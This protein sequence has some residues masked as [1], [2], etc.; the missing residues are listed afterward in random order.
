MKKF[1]LSLACVLGLGTAAQAQEAVD[2]IAAVLASTSGTTVTVSSD[3]VAVGQ[4]GNNLWIKDSSG[5]ILVYGSTDQTYENG[6]VIPAGYGGKFSPYKNLPE[7]ASP[8]GF[9]KG[10]NAGAVAPTACTAAN[11]IEQPLCSY[12]EIRGEVVATGTTGRNFTLTDASG[13]VA[14]YTTSASVKVNTG[15]DVIVRGFVSI[16]NTNYQ[17]SPIESIVVSGGTEPTVDEVANIAEFISAA[18]TN[19]TKINT[20][21]TV[22]YQLGNNL[23]IK[24]ASGYLLVY[25]SVGQTYQSGDVIKAGYSGTYSNYKNL[26]EM[27]PNATNFAAATSNVGAVEPTVVFAG[28]ANAE[29][30]SS[31]IELQGV[32]ITAKADGTA[33]RDYIASDASG[34][35]ILHTASS[36]FV[37]P[38]GE[39]MTVRGFVSIYDATYQITPVEIV[40]ASGLETVATPSFS[41]AGGEVVSGTEVAIS[42]ATEGATIYY[43]LDGT[44]PTTAS[45]VYSAPIVV[46]EAVTISAIAVKDG[47]EDSE[48]ANASY[49]I[50][51]IAENEAMFNF[52]DPSTLNPAYTLDDATADGSTGNFL[53]N[54]DDVAFTVAEI[55]V[56][57][58]KVSGGTASRLYY[59][60]ASE[61]W[62]YRVYKNYSIEIASS[63]DNTITKVTMVCNKGGNYITNGD[64]TGT[65]KLVEWTAP[66]GGVSSVSFATTGTVVIE[67]ITVEAS[68]KLS[69][70]ENVT[71][72]DEN[73]PVEYFNL[74]GVRV[75]NPENGLYIRRQGNTVS[76]V[77]IR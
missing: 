63:S 13:S 41:P 8:T 47:M 62:T 15:E 36:S 44:T 26:V 42:C 65:A 53:I 71:I 56:K 23:W 32:T 50:L 31:F 66:E 35:A 75:A 76:K 2:N 11:C 46:T 48:V 28:D 43:T 51:T 40:N 5:W 73:A 69:G 14:L 25:G 58:V 59:Q 54:V 34:E 33:G 1:L 18:S 30:I 12:I 6:D 3:A 21:A 17:I 20:D 19:E 77:V 74:Q 9:T 61:A 45:S 24:D 7:L 10:E 49:T 16:F 29:P 64:F 55:S 37:V 57:A 27:V 52:Q 60:T 68:G 22:Q 39:N 67:T 72:A 4:Q 70:V 38:E